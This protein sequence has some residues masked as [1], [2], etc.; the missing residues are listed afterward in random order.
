[1]INGLKDGKRVSTA[2]PLTIMLRQL[3]W[4]SIYLALKL[5]REE[6]DPEMYANSQIEICNKILKYIEEEKQCQ[7]NQ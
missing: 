6:S 1:M 3:L 5:V 2:K 4:Q 7:T